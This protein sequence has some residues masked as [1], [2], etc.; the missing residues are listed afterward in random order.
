MRMLNQGRLR[1]GEVGDRGGEQPEGAE[2]RNETERHGAG[3]DQRAGDR[4]E[5][6]RRRVG[7]TS[8]VDPV[9]G[10][11]PVAQPAPSEGTRP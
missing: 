9:E 6:R 10:A 11:V 1:V 5:R 3:E 7:A 4:A 8:V 2:Y